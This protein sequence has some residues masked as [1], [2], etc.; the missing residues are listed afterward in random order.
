M[1]LLYPDTLSSVGVSCPRGVL[2][3]GPP[4]VG[5]T[6]LVHRVAGEV[7]ANL[8]V[9]RGPEVTLRYRQLF[10]IYTCLH[11]VILSRVVYDVSKKTFNLSLPI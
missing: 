3:V 10:S 8:V 4:G 5:K 2:L 1:P 7:G 11:S 9:V 6:L